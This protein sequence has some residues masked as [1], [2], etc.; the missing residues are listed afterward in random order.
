MLEARLKSIFYYGI[1]VTSRK[2]LKSLSLQMFKLS[3]EI[4]FSE[5]I[6]NF[7]FFPEYIDDFSYFFQ[8]C[9][10]SCQ[11]WYACQHWDNYFTVF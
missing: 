5:Y 2:I 10:Q 7:Y 4:F 6:D 11:H 1:V 8:K 3:D 9:V